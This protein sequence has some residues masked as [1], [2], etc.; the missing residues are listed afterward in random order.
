MIQSGN[1]RFPSGLD[2]EPVNSILSEKG[3]NLVL[4]SRFT[5][6]IEKNLKFPLTKDGVLAIIVHA[7]EI[8][9]KVHK[10]L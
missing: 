3:G 10:V 7:A 8:A 2:L 6:G 9:A 4:Q 5:S 1:K